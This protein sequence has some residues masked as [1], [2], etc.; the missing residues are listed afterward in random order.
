MATDSRS[1]SREPSSTPSPVQIFRALVQI[2]II[3]KHRFVE[4]DFEKKKYSLPQMPSDVN[5]T[6]FLYGSNDIHDG[7]C[8]Q[9]IQISLR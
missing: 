1:G 7:E 6:A 4:L 8:K 3:Q 9:A 5:Q 2:E